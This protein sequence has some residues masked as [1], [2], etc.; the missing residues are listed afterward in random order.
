MKKWQEGVMF[1]EPNRL[2]IERRE[3]HNQFISLLLYCS[4]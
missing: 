1:V 2:K 3:Q 4:Y